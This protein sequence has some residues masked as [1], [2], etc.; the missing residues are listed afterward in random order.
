MLVGKS[1]RA[2]RLIC[3]VLKD[4]HN[5]GDAIEMKLA[6]GNRE[7]HLTMHPDEKIENVTVK[8]IFLSPKLE[9]LKQSRFKPELLQ[10]LIGKLIMHGI[11]PEVEVY[12]RKRKK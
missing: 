7:V 9:G 3:S 5:T 6:W 11:T 1:F 2:Y 12:S 4:I 10:R 8:I